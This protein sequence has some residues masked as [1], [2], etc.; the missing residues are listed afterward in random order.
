MD[1]GESL[2]FYLPSL[3]GGGAQRVTVN[4]AN[5]F[6]D[7]GV[8]VDL[9]VSYHTGELRHEVGDGVSIVDLKTPR[10]PLV[11]VGASIPALGRYLERETPS[12]LFSQM[13][14]ANVVSVVAHWLSTTET[15]LV[16]TEHTIFG[17]ASQ[18]K[19]TLMFSLAKRSHPLAD[20]VIAV[21]SGVAE[22]VRNNVDI[23]D[24]KVSVINNPIVTPSLRGRT[25]AAIDHPWLV[26]PG[27]DVILGVGRLAPE[28][29][30]TTLVRA[31]ALAQE[32]NPSLHLVIL[33]EGPRREELHRVAENLEVD[34]RVSL[35]GYVDNPYAYMRRADV[36]ALSSKRE[37]LPT[38]LVEAMACGC[39]VV[40]TDCR[41]G[42]RE[43]LH[44]GRYGPLV[45]VGDS[46][47][48]AAEIE[49]TLRNPVSSDV[50][51]KRAGDFSTETVLNEYEQLVDR[52]V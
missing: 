47:A 41:S 14:Y 39:P 35:P 13:H 4:L 34:D 8:N 19:D 20:H 11:G 52:L 29:D 17:K 36:F 40:A 28:K 50:L 24:S 51:K 12:V 25:E 5:G 7:R 9:V 26:D 16:L 46:E 22:S 42:P 2:A 45:P 18:P 43:I 37:G 48:L 44:D 1:S 31:I 27:V 38:A 15:A 10:I 3:T 21:S 33:G 30:F 6:V 32:A 49:R 23:P